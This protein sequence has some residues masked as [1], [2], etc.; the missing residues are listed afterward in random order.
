MK[1]N[2]NLPVKSPITD[3]IINANDGTSKRKDITCI[4]GVIAQLYAMKSTIT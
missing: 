4:K 1:V 2:V 3:I